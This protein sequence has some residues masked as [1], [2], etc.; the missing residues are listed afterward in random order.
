MSYNLSQMQA[1][2]DRRIR[3][4]LISTAFKRSPLLAFIPALGG[5]TFNLGHEK[6]L[7]GLISG[8]KIPK[9]TKEMLDGSRVTHVPLVT[10]L[11]G[12]GRTMTA[13]GTNPAVEQS[14]DQNLGSAVFYWWFYAQPIKVWLRTLKLAGRGKYAIQNALTTSVDLARDEMAAVLAEKFWSGAPSSYSPD[15]SEDAYDDLPGV[16]EAMHSSNSYGNID[17]SDTTKYIGGRHPWASTRVTAARGASLDLINEANQTCMVYGPGVNLALTTVD[18]YMAMKAEAEAKGAIVVTDGKIPN[19]GM[20]GYEKEF[21]QYG[22]TIITFDPYCPSGYFACFTTQDWN[23]EVHSEDNGSTSNWNQN[24]G[25]G[26][27]AAIEA[28]IDLAIRPYCLR[29]VNQH[30]HTNVSA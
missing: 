23:I 16:L 11:S 28:Q 3:R 4:T 8:Q 21:I 22:K 27:D 5:E 7:G 29:P 12:G 1:F 13:R 19:H 24:L 6:S 2:A 25:A 17:R 9:L 26:K 15:A 10:A 14:Q 20:V 30:L 18:I